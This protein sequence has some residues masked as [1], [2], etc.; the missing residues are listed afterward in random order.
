M[1]VTIEPT[2]DTYTVKNHNGALIGNIKK[3]GIYYY[4]YPRKDFNFSSY[5]L[6]KICDYL[7]GINGEE[8]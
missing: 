3:D 4:F 7:D 8:K 2:S 5:Q 1:T 6:G